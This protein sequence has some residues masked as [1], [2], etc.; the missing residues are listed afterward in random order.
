MVSP[1]RYMKEVGQQAKKV[2]WPS[3]STYS[4]TLVVVLVIVII[5]A[6]ILMLE[7]WLAG[8]LVN[9]LNQVFGNGSSAASGTSV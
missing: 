5:A 7:N 8:T 2:R 6:I 9:S 3:W 1:R 4:K